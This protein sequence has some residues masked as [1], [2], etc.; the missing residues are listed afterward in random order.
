MCGVSMH[1][2]PS[3][4][5]IYVTGPTQVSRFTKVQNGIFYFLIL[6]SG[7]IIWSCTCFLFMHYNFPFFFHQSAQ[8]WKNKQEAYLPWAVGSKWAEA[9]MASLLTLPVMIMAKDFPEAAILGTFI[10]W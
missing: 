5:V 3:F 6:I 10:Y 1:S 4:L 8:G 7:L 2:Y 9:W